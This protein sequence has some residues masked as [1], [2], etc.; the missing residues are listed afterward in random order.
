[1]QM[2][3]ICKRTTG[4]ISKLAALLFCLALHNGVAQS[5]IPS[6]RWSPIAAASRE[7]TVR[8]AIREVVPSHVLGSPAGVHILIDSLQGSFDASLGAYL[9]SEVQQALSNGQQVQVTGV[10]RTANGKDYLFARQL[11]VDGHQLTIRNPQ[12][13]LVH[14]SPPTGSNKTHSERNGGIQ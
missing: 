10:V 8:G 12:G 4:T 14:A 9:P 2:T 13:F 6:T 7:I 5:P 1:M 3:K 11:G